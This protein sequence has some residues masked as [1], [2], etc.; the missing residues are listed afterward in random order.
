MVEIPKCYVKVLPIQGGVSPIVEWSVSAEPR[1]GY[2]L[3]PAFTSDGTL[4]FDKQLGMWTYQNVTKT[5][6]YLYVGAYDA[7]V[8]VASNGSFIDGLNLDNNTSRVNV[9]TDKLSSVSGKYP[10]VGLTRAEFNTVATNRGAGWQQVSLWIESLLQILY[11]TE[12]KD[13]DSQ[14]ALSYG[15]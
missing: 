5:S 11:V 9:T 13:L 8:Q 6:D 1:L 2:I 10:M 14:A 12:Y 15:N 3:H 4:V 7:S